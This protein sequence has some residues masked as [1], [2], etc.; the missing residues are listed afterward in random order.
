M[1]AEEVYDLMKWEAGR[2]ERHKRWAGSPLP[3]SSSVSELFL[4]DSC[5]GEEG[6]VVTV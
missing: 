3:A 6:K 4:L 1:H 2:L 5:R